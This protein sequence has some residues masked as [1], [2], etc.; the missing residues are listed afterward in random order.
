MQKERILKLV[1]QCLINPSHFIVDVVV[2]SNKA[3]GK[4]LVL[5][6]GDEGFSI[7]DCADLSRKLSERL[8]AEG[9]FDSK[10]LLE[11]S[12]PGVDH[13]LTLLRQ[14][15]KN[16][17]RNV[18]VHLYEGEIVEGKITNASEE[19]LTLEQQIGKG[20][21]KEL[22]EVVLTFSNIKKT[23]VTISFK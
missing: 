15:K 5:V 20:K 16:V 4:V 10:Y 9:A 3:G 1:E 19:A 2:T 12:S 7:D 13:P 11:V 6:D 21:K 22:K 23:L 8:D 18:K 17:G 14:Y